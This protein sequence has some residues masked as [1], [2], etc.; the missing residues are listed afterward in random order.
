MLT[1]ICQGR[2]TRHLDEELEAMQSMGTLPRIAVIAPTIDIPSGGAGV[3]RLARLIIL[4]FGMRNVRGLAWR[5]NVAISVNIRDGVCLALANRCF[6]LGC[7]QLIPISGVGSLAVFYGGKLT[8]A[9]PVNTVSVNWITYPGP[10]QRI[11]C[12]I[13]MRRSSH[14]GFPSGSAGYSPSGGRSEST[15]RLRRALH[16]AV[17]V[18][19][20]RR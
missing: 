19:V 18:I 5:D 2:A 14:S 7:R 10:V 20:V 1:L 4:I 13:S 12:S 11:P 16:R 9:I 15:D 6:I 8:L 17:A 3:F